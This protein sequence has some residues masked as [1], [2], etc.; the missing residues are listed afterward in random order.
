[1]FVLAFL[2]RRL[3][4]GLVIV[5]L[6][7]LLIFTLLRVVPGDPVRLMAGGMAP[8][9]LIE[10]IATSM[11]LRDPILVQFGRYMGNVVQGDLG[12]SFVRPANGA[13]TGG[14]SFNDATRG[15]RAKV[16][17]LIFET[18]PMTLQL[19]AVTLVI[20]L[21][22]STII[23]VA[24]GLAPGRWPDKVAFYVSSIF[25]SLPNFWLGIV[26]ALLFS[27]HLGWLPAI[28]YNGF[29]YTILPAIVLAVELS[30]VLI[31]TLVSSVSSQM[32][33][34]YVSVGKVRGLGHARIVANHALR[35]ASVPLLNLLGVQFS[36]LLGGV[37]IVEFI[38]DYPGLGLL[39]IN[40]VLQ[41]DFPLIQGIAI[42]TSAIFVVINIVVDLV[43]TTI[44]P[45][46]EY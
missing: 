36:S 38:F 32:G 26:L 8:E 44:D 3:V 23:G 43:A 29:A 33:Q 30:P 27:V 14:S 9:A 17:D 31:R 16:A 2:A 25:I 6:V 5:F 15:E 40:A 37:I 19:A 42:V 39:T 24:G 45:R 41:R 46:L 13:A 1:M 11:G 35:N 7:S 10:Q 22:F 34:S 18:L 4:Q 12:Q 20:A 21:V 28:G